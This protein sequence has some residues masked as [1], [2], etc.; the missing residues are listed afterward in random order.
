MLTLHS[1]WILS[2]NKSSRSVDL[3]V[4]GWHK[5]HAQDS[6]SEECQIKLPSEKTE[7][8]RLP[9]SDA[10]A[11]TEGIYGIRGEPSPAESS[12]SW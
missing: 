5:F 12:K 2:T 8:D 3:I 6:E 9:T 4:V 11:S 1:M 10:Y 7:D